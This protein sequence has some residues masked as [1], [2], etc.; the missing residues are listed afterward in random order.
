MDKMNILSSNIGIQGFVE[1]KIESNFP[2][3]KQLPSTATHEIAVVEHFNI[4]DMTALCEKF[5][6][7]HVGDGTA[8]NPDKF[9][10]NLSSYVDKNKDSNNPVMQTFIK[11]VAK[12]IME[13]KE[14]LY[15][16]TNLLVGA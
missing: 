1:P 4:R 3:A 16:F 2:S 9:I 15:A 13:N 7:P 10:K 5:L 12:P 6:T 11:D 8:L 14:L